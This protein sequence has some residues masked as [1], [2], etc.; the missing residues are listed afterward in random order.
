[1]VLINNKF[2]LREFL[3]NKLYLF[4]KNNNFLRAFLFHLNLSSIIEIDISS[5]TNYEKCTIGS[6]INKEIDLHNELFR[7]FG[8]AAIVDGTPRPW[9][10]DIWGLLSIKIYVDNL[11][12]TELSENFKI[13]IA[14]F[15]PIQVNKG[16]FICYERDI[17]SFILGDD[18][19]YITA[20][21]PLFLHYHKIQSIYD[22]K[23]RLNLIHN[24]LNIEFKNNFINENLSENILAA[25]I[26]VFDRA[27]KDITIVPPNGWSFEDLC[28]YLNNITPNLRKWTWELKP[29]THGAEIVRW[30]INNEYHVQNL[31]YTL[32][33]PIFCDI[34]EE[35]NLPSIGQKKPR[36]DLYLPSLHTIIEV[37]YRK[38]KAKSFSELIGEIGEDA[39]LYLSSES[40]ADAKVIVFLWDQTRSTQ[41]H[42]T[43]KM[44][45]KG[46]SGISECIVA[47]SPS[48][49]E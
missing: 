47:N 18:K 34:K 4:S 23:V 32:L 38:N 8:Q 33:A 30:Q 6:L 46:I 11:K 22:N 20:I 39:S 44:G 26:Y 37:K 14:S 10:M 2:E 17:A 27:D 31:L 49:I 15:L 9:V 5:L 12:D 42:A 35:E 28:N 21:I 7:L 24:F 41:E 1:M 25:L 36:I 40:Y 45:I 16:H 13:W 19:N 43:F 3:L 48:F 29:R